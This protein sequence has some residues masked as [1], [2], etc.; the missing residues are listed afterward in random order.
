[1]PE[2][3]SLSSYPAD[4]RA[5]V[6]DLLAGTRY[7]LWWDASPLDFPLL[8]QGVLD[9]AAPPGAVS[10]FLADREKYY[11]GGAAFRAIIDIQC[12]RTGLGH[13][14]TL[15][16]QQAPPPSRGSELVYIHDGN[17]AVVS[18][19]VLPYANSRI[20]VERTDRLKISTARSEYEAFRGRIHFL[21]GGGEYSMVW[22]QLA[23]EVSDSLR[24]GGRFL[25]TREDPRW[26]TSREAP[27][28][29]LRIWERR[30]HMLVRAFNS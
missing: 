8:L 23:E 18:N 25:S 6:E 28:P 19:L 7:P 21:S 2:T 12:G 26:S 27:F 3:F 24:A 22:L 29:L 14:C 11:D 10:R 5:G 17:I 9:R 30:S 13:F 1:M 20:R 4:E 16:E 15:V